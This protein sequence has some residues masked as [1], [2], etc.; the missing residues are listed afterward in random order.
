LPEDAKI[1]AVNAASAA[2]P[3]LPLGHRRNFVL[4]EHRL[5]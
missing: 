2:M 4:M 1:T 3:N 5:N